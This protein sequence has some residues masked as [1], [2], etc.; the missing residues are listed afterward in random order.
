MSDSRT[1]S[2]HP[3]RWTVYLRVPASPIHFAERWRGLCGDGPLAR[4]PGAGRHSCQGSARRTS[5]ADALNSSQQQR[6][7]KWKT[8]VMAAAHAGIF[9]GS[10]PADKAGFTTRSKWSAKQCQMITVKSLYIYVCTSRCQQP[11]ALRSRSAVR[12]ICCS[13]PPV[14]RPLLR[15]SRGPSRANEQI[16]FR[17]LNAAQWANK[18]SCHSNFLRPSLLKTIYSVFHF[19]INFEI[20]VYLRNTVKCCMR[21][22]HPAPELFDQWCLLFLFFFLNG[23]LIISVYKGR[24]AVSTPTRLSVHLTNVLLWLTSLKVAA[25]N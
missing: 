21:P 17:W 12:E 25:F 5:T 15:A 3:R 10:L 16:L 18:D 24:M 13:R 19:K 2:C 22:Q 14:L 7:A 11:R 9:S 20:R 1:R 6:R 8:C 23:H 4:A